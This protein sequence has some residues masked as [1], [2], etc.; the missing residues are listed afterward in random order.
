MYKYWAVA[1]ESDEPSK[2]EREREEKTQESHEIAAQTLEK[3]AN[4]SGGLLEFG[5]STILTKV[6]TFFAHFFRHNCVKLVSSL[7]REF[8]GIFSRR[9]TFFFSFFFHIILN[10]TYGAKKRS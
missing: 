2:R 3:L 4:N 7:R 9:H 10:K 8:S 6:V 1:H 5:H